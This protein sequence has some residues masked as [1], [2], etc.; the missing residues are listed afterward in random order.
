MQRDGE[1]VIYDEADQLEFSF[2]AEDT[3]DRALQTA[4]TFMIIAEGLN[5]QAQSITDF[6]N[7]ALVAQRRHLE[8]RATR[9]QSTSNRIVKLFPDKVVDA[10]IAPTESS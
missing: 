2:P 3:A 1:K 5:N 9:L 10:L 8:Y 4:K 7:P 6:T